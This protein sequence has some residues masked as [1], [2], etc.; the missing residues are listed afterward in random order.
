MKS[1]QLPAILLNTFR[2]PSSET[3]MTLWGIRTLF[4]AADASP[5]PSEV[6]ILH[7][8]EHRKEQPS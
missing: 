7:I 8:L 3:L 1:L 2:H 5:S 6:H 4:S